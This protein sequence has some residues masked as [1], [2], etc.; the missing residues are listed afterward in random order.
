MANI[1]NLF[2][3]LDWL[4]AYR[5]ARLLY[6]TSATNKAKQSFTKAIAL[7]LDSSYLY[8]LFSVL[9]C[10]VCSTLTRRYERQEIR[11][12][13]INILLPKLQTNMIALTSLSSLDAVLPARQCPDV[14]C[15]AWLDRSAP[16][17]L[18]PCKYYSEC[19]AS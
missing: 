13:Y 9:T 6:T 4:Q 10:L 5:R 14:C 17:Y 3:T 12:I 7:V 16:I 18:G 11:C 15:D 8:H 2:S 19:S 1:F